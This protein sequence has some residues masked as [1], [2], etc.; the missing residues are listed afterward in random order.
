MTHPKGEEYDDFITRILGNELACKVKEADLKD[1][2]NLDRLPM[3][4]EEDLDRLQK[5]QKSL[6]R[7][8]SR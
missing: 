1:N 7:L 6:K 5:Y 3:V 4:N 8:N 2:M